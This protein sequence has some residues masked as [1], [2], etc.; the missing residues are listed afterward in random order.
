MKNEAKIT[1]GTK[2]Q[3]MQVV[4]QALSVQ[5]QRFKADLEAQQ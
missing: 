1:K 2:H 5:E 3:A 4:K